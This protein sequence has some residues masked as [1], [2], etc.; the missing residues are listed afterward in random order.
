MEKRVT[1]SKDCWKPGCLTSW[2][3][4]GGDG[5][6][7]DGLSGDFQPACFSPRAGHAFLGGV[8]PEGRPPAKSVQG[9]ALSCSETI[10]LGPQ[11]PSGKDCF[12]NKMSDLMRSM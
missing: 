10:V 3:A 11:S 1:L 12:K 8:I 2:L 5:I 6:G 7:G 4:Q 9:S